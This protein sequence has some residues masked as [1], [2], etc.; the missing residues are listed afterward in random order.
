[1]L[2]RVEHWLGLDRVQRDEDRLYAWMVYFILGTN[3]IAT[4]LLRVWIRPPE[5]DL[6]N[7]SMVITLIF[8]VMTRLGWLPVVRW[9]LPATFFAMITL[10]SMDTG[11]YS[12]A[13]SLFPVVIA[14]AGFL[15]NR[16]GVVI[17]TALSIGVIFMLGRLHAGG[18]FTHSAVD[19]A[20]RPVVLAIILLVNGI[21]LLVL[22]NNSL[23]T[24]SGLRKND[25]AL[26]ESNRQLQAGREAL[27][28]EVVERTRNAEQARLE[29]ESANRA[30]EVRVWQSSAES[31][32]GDILRGEQ[33]TALL[34][35]RVIQEMCQ[36]VDAPVGCLFVW[37]KGE[38]ALLGS[39]AFMHRK[40]L[41]LRFKPGEGLVGQAARERTVLILENPPA[42][43]MMISMGT[44]Q[45]Q[46]RQVVAIPFE[47]N[48]QVLGVVEIAFLAE[49]TEVQLAYLQSAMESLGIAFGT[50]QARAQVDELLK[51]TQLQA[52]ELGRRERELQAVNEELQVQAENLR[53]SQ[54]RLQANQSSLEAANAELEEKTDALQQQRAAVDAQNRELRSAQEELQHYAGELAAAN[55][56]KSEFLANMSHE[57]RTPLNSL[58]I[59]ARML[60]GNETGNLTPDQVKSAEVIYNSGSDLL[61][62][63]NDILDLSK[64]EAGRMEFHIESMPLSDLLDSMR[65]QF[66]PLADERQ[67]QFVLSIEDGL[68]ESIETDVQRLR[69]VVKNLLSNAFKFTE[70]GSV[71]L[72]IERPREVAELRKYGLE[73]DNTV[74]VRV[75]DTGIGVAP[76]K[77]KIIFEAF[78]QA[79]GSTNR[80]F[81][82]TGLGL[83]IAREMILRL[84]GFIELI[85]LPGEGSTFTVVHPLRQAGTRPG[86]GKEPPAPVVVGLPQDVPP[87]AERAAE[88]T[89]EWQVSDK[90]AP[91]PKKERLLLLIEDDPA[92][93]EIV[94]DLAKKKGFECLLAG[95]GEAGLELARL[96]RP[97]AVILDLRLPGMSGWDVLDA[98]KK[99]SALRHIP[100]H[101]MS[102]DDHSTEAFQRG[103]LGYLVKPVSPESI[104]EA[105]QQIETFLDRRIKSLL[106]VEDDD[107]TR[108]GITKLLSGADVEITEACLGSQ[109]LDLLRSR[110]FDCM[111]VDLKLPDADGFTILETIHA[112]SQIGRCPIIV[113]TGRELTEEENHRLIQ[114]ADSVIVKGAR[115]PERL[116]D[117]TALFLHRVV[118]D[119][120]EVEQK[121]AEK[122]Y[123][124][125]DTLRGKR[126]LIVDDD[127]R[128]SF[129]LSRLLSDKGIRV[130]IA[131]NGQKALDML[132]SDPAYDLVLMDIMMPVMDGL[133]AIRNIRLDPKLRKLP[134]LALTAK[135]MK[136]DRE[137][138]IAAGADDY[139]SKPV[140]ADKLFSMLRVW[141]YNY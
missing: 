86:S 42:G 46:P 110:R 121:S 25:E 125:E 124:L 49:I 68:P 138:C 33:D 81:G 80:R 82:G 59:L 120:P 34:A 76:E 105:F 122:T 108:L 23:K 20:D 101:I 24:L 14:L 141:L 84:G 85:S 137:R 100:V 3:L 130:D 73:A 99:D 19:G 72:L 37:E 109:A 107:K 6:I 75:R 67:L 32:L 16:R 44:L 60:A 104:E 77:Q 58:L 41:N 11:L 95:T 55:R 28:Q 45:A 132:A 115:S 36:T 4:I 62:L 103:V 136:G 71:S 51:E 114:V 112:D 118:A 5:V 129:A 65:V 15:L 126:I 97:Q 98:L 52:S 43:Y 35:A 89:P 21:F 111:I 50:A 57:L 7:Q 31:R 116:L 92:F 54:D 63:I 140:D 94:A 93:A 88:Q 87:P 2:N 17:F 79:D 91:A 53:L 128:N 134:V 106:V 131:S 48:N 74:C 29:A 10:G 47:F 113:Y 133:E 39:Y 78:Q 56:Y 13:I 117:E 96:R 123:L 22:I 83:A 30:M 69:Q 8:L 27:E 70:K 135:A 40:S 61:N 139:L 26:E 66:Q 1:M 9:L 127:M 12:A 102:A 90:P 18:Q 119:M 38:Y 64:V